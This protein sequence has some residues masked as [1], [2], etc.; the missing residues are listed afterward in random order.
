V[1]ESGSV[2]PALNE[3]FPDL[4]PP[5]ERT[6]LRQRLD[7]HRR[8]VIRRIEDLDDAQA[9]HRVLAATDLTV[10]GVVKHLAWVEDHWFQARLLGVAV[11]EPWA[12]ALPADDRDWPFRSATHDSVAQLIE[13][14]DAAC[15]RSRVAAASF[16]SLDAVAVLPSFGKGPV[17]LRWIL[18]H[19]I[20]ETACHTG[21][22]DLLRDA[23]HAAP[24]A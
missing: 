3:P 17:N 18:V 4:R 16:D 2:E 7:H 11:P 13:L 22:L 8:A 5:D 24:D 1:E 14:Y 15:E 20:D 23:I 12:S 9:S 19:M 21:H 10:G 6:A